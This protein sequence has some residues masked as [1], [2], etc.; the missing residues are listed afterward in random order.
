[1]RLSVVIS[2]VCLYSGSTISATVLVHT[3][4]TRVWLSENLYQTAA[5]YIVAQSKP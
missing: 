1:M 2:S 5:Y 3:V 4:L